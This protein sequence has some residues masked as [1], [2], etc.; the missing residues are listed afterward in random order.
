MLSTAGFHLKKQ[1]E[2]A[3]SILGINQIGTL[4]WRGL[5]E[6]MYWFA[7]AVLT[8]YNRLGRLTG[9]N[10]FTD[11]EARSPRTKCQHI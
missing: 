8:K 4:W 10:F 7:R 9:I 3:N 6:E 1:E 5:L 11:L 2:A